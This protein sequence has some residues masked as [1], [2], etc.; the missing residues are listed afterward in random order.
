MQPLAAR[1]RP[2]G[3]DD[4][5]HEHGKKLH[6]KASGRDRPLSHW[7]AESA[8]S[9][10]PSQFTAEQM[11]LLQEVDAFE[12]TRFPRIRG[13]FQRAIPADLHE[14]FTAAF[15]KDLSQQPLGPTVLDSVSTLLT[16]FGELKESDHPGARQAYALGVKR[17][18]TEQ[19][20]KEMQA[21]VERARTS[22]PKAPVKLGVSADELARAQR[23]QMEAIDELRRW[24]NDWATTFRTAF[25]TR[26]LVRLGLATLKRGDGGEKP[27][28]GTSGGEGGGSGDEE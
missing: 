3:Y 15:F 1:V 21:L 20:V 27:G 16:R 24:Y 23:E 10:E 6:A 7:I 5:E 28:S 19:K 18:L 9:G 2:L 25:G 17:G 8:I 22:L 13:I 4:E 11:R 12:N 14:T 26:I